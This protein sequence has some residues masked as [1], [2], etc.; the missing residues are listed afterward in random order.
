MESKEIKFQLLELAR[1]V[2]ALQAEDAETIA[3]EKG[4]TS[5]SVHASLFRAP[6]RQACLEAGLDTG[7][8][9]DKRMQ[10]FCFTPILWDVTSGDDNA[11]ELGRGDEETVHGLTS[12]T[13]KCAEII[14]ES[15]VGH[16]VQSAEELPPEVSAAE[17]TKRAA[18][19]RVQISRGNG[20]ATLR[21]RYEIGGSRFMLTADVRRSDV[22]ADAEG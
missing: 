2:V 22:D 18:N 21:I 4:R 13:D 19:F 16:E 5:Y 20:R 11:E 8:V 6:L 17:L 14:A 7:T 15:H 10:A 1:K 3:A 9:S 12:V